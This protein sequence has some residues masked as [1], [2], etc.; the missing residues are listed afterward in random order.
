[1]DF[2]DVKKRKKPN[3]TTVR[4]VLDPE[5]ADKLNLAQARVSV[6]EREQKLR[7]EVLEAVNGAEDEVNPLTLTRSAEEA[8]TAQAELDAAKNALD[9]LVA[10]AD[11]NMI[12]FRIRGLSAHEIDDL[13]EEYQPTA[14]QKADAKK[15]NPGQGV[16][17]WN[18]DTFQPALVHAAML[19]PEWT[20]E[21]VQELWESPDWN[22]E[23]L[24][25]LYRAAWE[26]T[27]GRRVVDLGEG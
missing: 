12:S 25:D 7:T 4:I 10:E 14:E 17:R 21:Q 24:G 20:L 3:V 2:E 26:Q 27:N 19:D 5:W 8:R 9:E 6:A 18:P 15:N 16:P 11:D 22:S 1:M 23:E 13:I